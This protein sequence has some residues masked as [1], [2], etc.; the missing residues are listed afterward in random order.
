MAGMRWAVLVPIVLLA[1]AGCGDDSDSAQSVDSDQSVESTT[2]TTTAPAAPVPSQ[3]PVGQD[4]SD[5][6]VRPVLASFP[7]TPE[8]VE[9]MGCLPA[10]EA[11]WLPERELVVQA[12]D[13]EQCHSLGPVAADDLV[14]DA[15]AERIGT[16]W[17]IA[18]TMSADGLLAFNQ[19]AAECFNRSPTCTT[20]Q[21]AL[22]VDEEV[23]SAPT[24]QQPEFDQRGVTISGDFTEEEAE[25]LA[26]RIR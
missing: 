19:I 26:S 3:E 13:G 22:V 20:G 10:T 11:D 17:S 15:A 12:A 2:T 6:T 24:I 23:L 18:V 21:L 16:G 1:V 4:R 9:T 25:D 5:L 7:N 14:D 8:L